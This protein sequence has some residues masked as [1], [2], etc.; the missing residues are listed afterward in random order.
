MTGLMRKSA[1]T[2]VESGCRAC[3]GVK[4]VPEECRPK[5]GVE[6]PCSDDKDKDAPP[7]PPAPSGT[8]K[9]KRR[10]ERP[11][12]R[13]VPLLL[14]TGV[15][16]VE[17]KRV[18]PAGESSC[19]N[20]IGEGAAS[21]AAGERVARGGACPDDADAAAGEAAAA[22]AARDERRVMCG[23]GAAAEGEAATAKGAG[24]RAGDDDD[25]APAARLDERR[26]AGDAPPPA[27]AARAE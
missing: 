21:E 22:P 5:S 3:M 27:A 23:E 4:A 1:A 9:S 16:R 6:A 15:C 2:G 26:D 7:P 19:P 17:P 11:P 20:A 12:L 18:R 10:D 8:V 13:L 14:S 25:P 24:E